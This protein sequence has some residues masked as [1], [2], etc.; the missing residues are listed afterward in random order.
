MPKNGGRAFEGTY[1]N[2]PNIE[3]FISS[4]E[5]KPFRELSILKKIEPDYSR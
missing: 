1:P 4:G 5:T 2:W 3:V